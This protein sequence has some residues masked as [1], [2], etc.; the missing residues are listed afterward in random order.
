MKPIYNRKGWV[1]GRC[2]VCGRTN[3][4]EPHGTT[5][6]CRCR[7]NQETEHRNIPYDE[8]TADGNFLVTRGNR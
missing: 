8:R 2:T 4:V 7:P 5:A 6:E 1:L 3:Y